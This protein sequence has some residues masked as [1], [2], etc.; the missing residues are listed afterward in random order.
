[1][2]Q[3]ILLDDLRTKY[4]VN[5]VS[6]LL[7]SS[8][9]NTRFFELA[10]YPGKLSEYVI[11]GQGFEKVLEWID[12]L[13][14]FKA[15]VEKCKIEKHFIHRYYYS[16][17][18]NASKVM[19]GSQLIVKETC[20]LVNNA[21]SSYAVIYLNNVCNPNNF[22]GKCYSGKLVVGKGYNI[23]AVDEHLWI[24]YDKFTNLI[25]RVSNSLPSLLTN[26]EAYEVQ[27]S[28]KSA[29]G[30]FEF[31][32]NLRSTNDWVT[33]ITNGEVNLFYRSVASDTSFSGGFVMD[34]NSA[35]EPSTSNFNLDQDAADIPEVTLMS[36]AVIRRAPLPEIYSRI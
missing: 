23:Q 7:K 34:I 14:T 24:C 16:G 8:S 32:D 22:A 13:E 5:Q 29:V 36:R 9:V 35:N 6:S 31:E 21:T 33:R 12:K 27:Y 25:T 15:S 4:N 2:K 18:T 28:V 30:A 1:M 11:V 26:E 10:A 3:Q 17:D 20:D 19:L